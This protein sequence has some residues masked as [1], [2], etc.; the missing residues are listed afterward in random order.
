MS[1]NLAR[2]VHE[3]EANRL[4]VCLC[5]TSMIK[6]ALVVEIS[7]SLCFVGEAENLPGTSHLICVKKKEKRDQGYESVCT[8][9]FNG[10]DCL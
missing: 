10:R 7:R 2:N 5:V 4:A 6:V 8:C 9:N 3:R 1:H